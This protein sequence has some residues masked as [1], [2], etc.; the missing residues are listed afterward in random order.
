M[1]LVRRL[2]DFRSD[3][4]DSVSLCLLF[5]FRCR[6][7]SSLASYRLFEIALR[8][9]SYSRAEAIAR[10]SEEY[11]GCAKD[12]VSM[13]CILSFKSGNLDNA[14]K[15]LD[16]CLQ[17][18]D[19]RA[20][21]RLLFRTG[22]RPADLNQRFLVLDRIAGHQYVLFSHRCYVRIAQC[23]QVLNLEDVVLA[24]SLVPS[25]RNLVSLLEEDEHVACCHESNRKN[26]GKMLISLCTVSYHI[27]LLLQDD[28]L[29]QFACDVAGRFSRKIDFLKFNADACLRMS[30]NLFRCLAISFLL[31]G[32][33]HVDSRSDVLSRL[34]FLE[35][36]VVKACLPAQAGRRYATQ[37]NHLHFMA[38]L[39]A[40]LRVVLGLTDSVSSG[41]H[42]L[43]AQL[44]NHSSSKSLTEV[45][46]SRLRGVYD[47]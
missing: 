4:R 24:S 14:F 33:P 40:D 31:P 13:Q 17:C 3:F 7:H 11:Y 47:A 8:Q 1:R 29:L 23:Y 32:R 35:S 10:I 44:L 5:L 38:A 12:V 27:A 45:I 9:H 25:L 22:S 2:T 37:E 43:L 16:D 19:F 21:E 26:R 28:S 18:G 15:Y 36:S 6:L 30:S 41:T 20:L 46:E 34:A 39:Q 42:A